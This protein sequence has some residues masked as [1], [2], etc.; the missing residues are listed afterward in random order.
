MDI[1]EAISKATEEGIKHYGDSM[2][3]KFYSSLKQR[4]FMTTKCMSCGNIDFPPRPFCTSCY[5]DKV[6][7]IEIPKKGKVYSFTFQKRALRFTYPDIIGFVEID[8]IGRILTKI[9]G[10]NIKV[11]DEVELDFIEV[12]GVVLHKFVKR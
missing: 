2:T 3:H 9:E 4:K 7:W 1:R 6:E 12:D 8:G 5:S 11:G 10:E